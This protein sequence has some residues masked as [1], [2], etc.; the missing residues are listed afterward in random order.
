MLKDH[1]FGDRK[2]AL[3]CFVPWKKAATILIEVGFTV[4]I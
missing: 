4:G 2:D 3:T 1:Y